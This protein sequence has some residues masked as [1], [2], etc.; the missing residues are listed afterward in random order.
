LKNCFKPSC[1]TTLSSASQHWLSGQTSPCEW[2]T[3]ALP[4]PEAA[5][6]ITLIALIAP[7]AH[8]G[9]LQLGLAGMDDPMVEGLAQASQGG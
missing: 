6:T 7:I 5:D 3:N 2:R 4:W 1:P 9:I 8:L